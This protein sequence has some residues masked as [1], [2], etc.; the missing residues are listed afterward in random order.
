MPVSIAIRFGKRVAI[1]AL[2]AAHHRGHASVSELHQIP[3]DRRWIPVRLAKT[4]EY[5][6]VRQ[7]MLGTSEHAEYGNA[8]SRRPE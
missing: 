1:D 3:V 5:V 2:S 6:G 4:I 8:W 7:W